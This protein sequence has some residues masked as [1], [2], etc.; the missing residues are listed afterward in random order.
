[1]SHTLKPVTGEWYRHLDKGQPF[2]VVN[3]ESKDNLV[4]IQT[5]DGDLEEVEIADWFA[6][7]LEPAAAP[8]DWTGPMDDIETDDLGY[9]DTAMTD[10]DWRASLDYNKGT[11]DAPE[12]V[13]DERTDA[14]PGED[15][16]ED[17]A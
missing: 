13:A 8:E 7:D 2:R 15:S 16:T 6:M 4:E 12:A 1:M 11:E 10:K 3:I 5:F 17:E 9:E 14:E